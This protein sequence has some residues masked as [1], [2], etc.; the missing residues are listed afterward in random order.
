MDGIFRRLFSQQENVHFIAYR[1]LREFGVKIS[2]EKLGESLEEHP[3]YPS[4]LAIN[5]V[6]SNL[7]LETLAVRLDEHHL[8]QIRLPFISRTKDKNLFTLVRPREDIGFDYLEPVSGKW[9]V[10]AAGE[11]FKVLAPVALFAEASEGIEEKADDQASKH[12]L[13]TTIYSWFK[14]LLLPICG[15]LLLGWFSLTGS[16]AGFVVYLSLYLLGTGVGLLLL[17]FEID[18]HNPLVRQVCS[19]GGGK[20]NCNAVLYSKGSR[21]LGLSWSL[22]GFSYFLAGWITLSFVNIDSTDYLALLSVLSLAALPYVVY[23]LYYQW[24]IVKQ[25][26][27]LCLAVQTILLVQATVVLYERWYLQLGHIPSFPAREVLSLI[28]IFALTVI[29]GEYLIKYGK[30]GKEA[31][32]SRKAFIRLKSNPEIFDSLLQKQKRITIEPKGL[33]ITLGDPNA[34]HTLIKVCNPYCGPCAGAHPKINRLLSQN[35]DLKVQIIFTA[36]N[37]ETDKRALPVKHF[38]AIAQENDPNRIKT[39]IDDWYLS[40]EKNYGVFAADYPIGGNLNDYIEQVEK[41]RKWCDNM[42]IDHTP[43]YFLNGF[44]LPQMYEISDMDYFL[45]S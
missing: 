39:A 1:Y 13:R 34:K 6:F 21:I 40:R 9:K 2:Q 36:S 12:R 37:E 27:R 33:G 44:E 35:L 38:L 20:V 26:C 18:R 24:R 43:T 32:K 16:G 8:S 5:D 42:E 11:F 45:K 41:M 3:D 28:L 15:V 30:Q 10:L 29:A 7:G 17:L 31:K 14:F 19:G 4:M 22:I 25:W 23:S